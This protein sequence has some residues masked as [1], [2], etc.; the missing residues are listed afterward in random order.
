M[1]RLLP[2]KQMFSGEMSTHSRIH[3]CTINVTPEYVRWIV[4]RTFRD[5][6]I[7]IFEQRVTCTGLTIFFVIKKECLKAN[8]NYKNKT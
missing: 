4:Q 7:F 5:L 2:I 1:V 3:H 6:Y 8:N